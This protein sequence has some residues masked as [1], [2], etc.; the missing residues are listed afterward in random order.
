M[1]FFALFKALILTLAIFFDKKHLFLP[2]NFR[3]SV[4]FRTFVRN[5]RKQR[6]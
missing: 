4:F 6:K 2:K 1:L 3:I 5:K